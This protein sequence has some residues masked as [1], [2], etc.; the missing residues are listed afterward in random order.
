MVAEAQ[1]AS[2]ARSLSSQPQTDSFSWEVKAAKRGGALFLDRCWLD[3]QCRWA[4]P[5]VS[6]GRRGGE[7]GL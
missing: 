6:G 4:S 7:G 3:Y 1:E 5:L 2:P